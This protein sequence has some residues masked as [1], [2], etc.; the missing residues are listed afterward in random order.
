MSAHPLLHG[1]HIDLTGG[2]VSTTIF[3]A[4]LVAVSVIGAGLCEL[5]PW[6]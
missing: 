2:H 5:I 3:I 4:A 6:R 1:F